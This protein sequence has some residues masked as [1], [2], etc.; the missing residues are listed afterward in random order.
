MYFC[1]F[2]RKLKEITREYLQ[3]KYNKRKEDIL[4][5]YKM[6]PKETLMKTLHHEATER[7]AW[8]PFAGVHAADRTGYRKDCGCVYVHQ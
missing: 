7:V 1:N 8:V 2:S 4:G 3:K 6:T 5:E